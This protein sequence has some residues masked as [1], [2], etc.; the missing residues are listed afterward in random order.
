MIGH[1]IE[2]FTTDSPENIDYARA[3][4]W[5]GSAM[6]W[7]GL[8]SAFGIIGLIILV[9]IV[10]ERFYMDAMLTGVAFTLIGGF[11]ALRKGFQIASCLDPF[12][13][14]KVLDSRGVVRRTPSSHAAEPEADPVVE[15]RRPVRPGQLMDDDDLAFAVD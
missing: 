3:K 7:F 8:W 12:A 11:F 4:R 2:Q 10:V 15:R 1:P 13:R 14:N 9:G 6:C 5:L